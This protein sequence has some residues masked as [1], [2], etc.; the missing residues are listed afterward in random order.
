LRLLLEFKDP[1][2]IKV[3][4]SWNTSCVE[5][6]KKF[7]E[8]EKL[9]LKFEQDST[10]K[11]YSINVRLPQEDF[12]K[13]KKVAAEMVDYKFI[14]LFSDATFD[15]FF[16]VEVYP[17]L[18]IIDG[19]NYVRFNGPLNTSMVPL[20]YNPVDLINEFKKK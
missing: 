7:P 20:V 2:K 19:N 3:I 10:V 6:F 17:K 15:G 11:F 1:R 8:H 18:I 9:A 16:K 14:N 13:V 4:D 12:D 5:C